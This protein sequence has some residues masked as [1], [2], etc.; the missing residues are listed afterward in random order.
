MK[1]WKSASTCSAG[2]TGQ[3]CFNGATAMKPWKS[4]SAPVVATVAACGFNGATAMKPWK[5]RSMARQHGRPVLLQWGH[6]DEAVEEYASC[7]ATARL[8]CR[9][10]WGHGDEAVEESGSARSQADGRRMRFNGATAMKPWKRRSLPA[11]RTDRAVGFN[12]AT[13]MKPW[14]RAGDRDA[15]LATEAL[16]WGHGDEAVE[17]V[18]DHRAIDQYARRASM[19]PRR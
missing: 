5:R 13:A 2:A 9:L 11:C 14:K 15:D 12:G 1:P 8:A 4:A 17:E 3:R 18:A 7:G 16:Q 10:Q 6:G 19:G